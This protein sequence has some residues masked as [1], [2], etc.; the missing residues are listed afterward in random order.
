MRLAPL[1]SALD[2]SASVRW[3][4]AGEQFETRSIAEGGVEIRGTEELQGDPM[5]ESALALSGV[6]SGTE[7]VADAASKTAFEDHLKQVR[8]AQLAKFKRL[9]AEHE[10]HVADKIGEA[11]RERLLRILSGFT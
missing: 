1:R 4:S 9:A 10:R 5:A 2:R 8:S 6:V 3:K 11:N 7:F